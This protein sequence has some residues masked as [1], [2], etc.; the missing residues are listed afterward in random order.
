MR[1]SKI[2]NV[3]EQVFLN[4]KSGEASS[5]IPKGTPVV[6]ELNGTD[7][8]LAVVLPA[9]GG[10]AFCAAAFGV[11]TAAL[12]AG[13]TGQVQAFGFNRYSII[14]RG[15]R[16]ASSDSW[17][18]SAAMSTG[19]LLVI[20]TVNNCFSTAASLAASAFLPLGLLVESVASVAASAT[21]T[22]DTRTVITT[23]AKTF[24]RML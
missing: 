6:L 9:T 20:D 12:A 3:V 17:T 14:R 5:S 1:N 18:S 7:D 19:Q 10:T 22:S 13:A 21:A 24:L 16:A 11:T 2:G 8:G 23:S 4:V 15:T